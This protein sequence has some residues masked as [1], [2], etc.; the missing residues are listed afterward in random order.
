MHYCVSLLLMVGMRLISR[1]RNA[2]KK[3]EDIMTFSGAKWWKV[4]FHVHTPASNCYKASQ[5]GITPKEFLL[6]AMEKEID[7]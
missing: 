7:C 5:K 4:D 6:N 1:S 2:F 3:G